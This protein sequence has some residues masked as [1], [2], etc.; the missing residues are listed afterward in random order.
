M[1]RHIV[2]TQNWIDSQRKRIIENEACVVR[3][4]AGK[5]IKQR[6]NPNILFFRPQFVPK[7]KNLMLSI[8]V[9]YLIKIKKTLI[10]KDRLSTKP[11]SRGLCLFPKV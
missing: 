4:L 8:I 5:P 6:L 7:V 11:S 10:I 2:P 1:V 3:I 9:F